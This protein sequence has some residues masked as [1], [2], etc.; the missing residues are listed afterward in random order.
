M[1]TGVPLVMGEHPCPQIA[2]AEASLAKIECTLYR[3]RPAYVLVLRI[4]LAPLVHV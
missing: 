2:K 1:L 3:L 4:V